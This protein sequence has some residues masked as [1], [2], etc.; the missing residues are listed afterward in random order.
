MPAGQHYLDG[1][2]YILSALGKVDFLCFIPTLSIVFVPQL[3]RICNDGSNL[4]LNEEK[5]NGG[6]G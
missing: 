4:R 5:K 6:G 2:W 1:Q 3:R